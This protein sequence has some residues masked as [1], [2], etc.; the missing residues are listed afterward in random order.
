MIGMTIGEMA[1][2][3]DQEKGTRV[4]QKVDLMID[5]EIET[6]T[7]IVIVTVTANVNVIRG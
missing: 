3:D 5:P 4:D 1:I 7:V 2:E 6:E